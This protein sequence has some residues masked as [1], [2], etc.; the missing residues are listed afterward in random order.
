[1]PDIEERG[2][3]AFR[4][5]VP[6]GEIPVAGERGNWL[7]TKCRNVNYHHRTKC[8][9]C[10]CSKPVGA[11]AITPDQAEKEAPSGP[12]V[13]GVNN[14][15]RCGK[16]QNVNFFYRETCNRCKSD[17]SIVEV[18]EPSFTV[19]KLDGTAVEDATDP[20]SAAS[21][22]MQAGAYGGYTHPNNTPSAPPINPLTG[23]PDL[24]AQYRNV[25]PS[26]PTATVTTPD[27]HAQYRTAATP[28]RNTAA[29]SLSALNLT[30]QQAQQ[31]N[32]MTASQKEIYAEY[33]LKAQAVNLGPDMGGNVPTSTTGQYVDHN[34]YSD[35]HLQQLA[36][37]YLQQE[38]YA[39]TPSY[40]ADPAAEDAQYYADLFSGSKK[41]HDPDRDASA[42]PTSVTVALAQGRSTTSRGSAPKKTQLFVFHI[43]TEMSE[44]NVWHLFQNSVTEAGGDPEE[45]QHVS[46]VR[47]SDG[48][49]K[50]F[51]FVHM[52]TR[53]GAQLAID[54]LHKKKIG[55]KWLTVQFACEGKKLREKER[56][57]SWR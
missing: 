55:K 14:A 48:E 35:Q 56:G 36:N 21:S 23:L 47:K 2:Q 29:T 26:T 52:R 39:A 46:V 22:H 32:Q 50:G 25:V 10:N 4:G 37:E 43:P 1:M 40:P 18:P 49:S 44:S 27:L 8:H 45:V 11:E 17:K 15:W 24:H 34:Q 16:C 57:R 38:Q 5:G 30:P 28:Y 41:Q 13:A 54:N 7:C 53:A 9:R 31:Y 42:A 3:K 51:G 33:L 6:P 19:K 12:P 20:I